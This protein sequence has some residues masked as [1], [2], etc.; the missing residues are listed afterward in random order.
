MSFASLFKA[1]YLAPSISL[2]IAD[3][4]VNLMQLSYLGHGKWP[5]NQHIYSAN[6]D[7]EKRA[8]ACNAILMRIGLIGISKMI[9]LLEHFL[10]TLKLRIWWILD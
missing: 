3:I 4:Q 7:P 6:Q 8:L 2:Y 9:R 5:S 1:Y 10:I